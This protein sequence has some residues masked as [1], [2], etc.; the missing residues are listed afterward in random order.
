VFTDRV[1]S[2]CL[3]MKSFMGNIKTWIVLWFFC[4]LMIQNRP[5]A[6]E[7]RK[8]IIGW[9]NPGDVLVF[10]KDKMMKVTGKEFGATFK[11]VLVLIVGMDLGFCN[12]GF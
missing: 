9:K 7:R 5:L 4:M 6:T 11:I 3:S 8:L 1:Y 12:L 2:G 10:M